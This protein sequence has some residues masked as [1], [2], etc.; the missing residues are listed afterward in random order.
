MSIAR[1]T[2]AD[3]ATWFQYRD[4]PMFLGSVLDENNSDSLGV[5]FLRYRAGESNEW[6]VTYDEVNIVTK[7][8]FTFRTDDA[9]FTA[10][11][12]ELL[13]ITTGTRVTYEAPEDAEV[14]FVTYPHFMPA[15]LASEH[16]DLL[17]DFH[18]AQLTL[19]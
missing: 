12:G 1:Y 11:A 10:K 3:V 4:R 2:I 17:G 18:P 8:S 16:A 15:Q 9:A 19:W 5:G 14:I 7:G 6:V 13:H